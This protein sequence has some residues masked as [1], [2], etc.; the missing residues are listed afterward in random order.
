MTKVQVV[1]KD[2][3]G[4]FSDKGKR[5]TQAVKSVKEDVL[6]SVL[7]E[8]KNIFF[9]VISFEDYYSAS[10]VNIEVVIKKYLDAEL[11]RIS[12]MHDIHSFFV[13]DTEQLI[14]EVKEEVEK[15]LTY[16]NEL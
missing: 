11:E 3:K 16:E 14:S 1:F 15:R 13:E 4:Y 6:K 12:M 9:T 2:V 7:G 10:S 5:S 8:I